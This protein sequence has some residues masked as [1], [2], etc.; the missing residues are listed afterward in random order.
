MLIGAKECLSPL[1]SLLNKEVIVLSSPEDWR[2][3]FTGLII[4]FDLCYA[5]ELIYFRPCAAKHCSRQVEK[6]AIEQFLNQISKN[7]LRTLDRRW[8]EIFEATLQNLS[9][10]SFGAYA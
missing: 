6:I 7:A 8:R 4:H 3:V 1:S 9:V 10:H 5:P 2:S